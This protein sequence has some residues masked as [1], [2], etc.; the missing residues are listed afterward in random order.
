ML[1]SVL[2]RYP[3]LTI[4]DIKL[5]DDGEGAFVATWN[6]EDPKPTPEQLK[7]WE[8]EDSKLPKPLTEIEETKKQITDLAFEL[9]IKG[10]L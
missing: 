10:V 2:K 7:T 6:S 9:M 8:A 3:N 5:Q 1:Q 4:N